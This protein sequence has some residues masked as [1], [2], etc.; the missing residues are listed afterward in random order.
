MRAIVL[1]VGVATAGLW[2]SIADAQVEPDVTALQMKA[3]TLIADEA[4]RVRCYD[5]A[6]SRPASQSPLVTV[7]Q[8][9]ALVAIP[10]SSIAVTSQPPS[11]A[12]PQPSTT[13][14][15]VVPSIPIPQSSIAAT[16]Q[17]GAVPQSSATTVSE[18]PPLA[19][20]TT[21]K[22]GTFFDRILGSISPS[23]GTTEESW[24]VKA[25]KLQLE[26][27]SQLLGTLTSADGNSTLVLKCN[28]NSIE[29]YVTTS[30]FLGWESLRVLYR[31]N[32]NPVIERRWAASAKGSEAVS[33]NAIEFINALTDNG[34]LMVTVFDYSGTKHD[35][36]FNLGSVSGLRSRIASVCRRPTAS[37]TAVR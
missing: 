35:I 17:P 14:T 21:P 2:A 37:S 10:Q 32:D 13:A 7:P 11:V 8:P 15:S 34:T 19:T 5:H 31:I 26:Q 3:C 36:N 33:D 25:D 24:Q 27:A 9:G 22:S 30:S 1:A 20:P 18:P 29:A 28:A 23:T 16:A 4:A 12:R 6:M